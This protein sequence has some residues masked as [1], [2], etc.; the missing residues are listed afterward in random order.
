[1]VDSSG[2]RAPPAELEPAIF[3]LEVRRLVHQAK[4]A[5]VTPAH[6]ELQYRFDTISKF[7]FNEIDIW[8]VGPDPKLLAAFDLWN[9][10]IADWLQA[11]S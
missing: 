1:M 3:G 5:G 2:M 9:P 6:S 4:G 11:T 8:M 10:F 7:G